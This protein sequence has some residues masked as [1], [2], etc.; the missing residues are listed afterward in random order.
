MS[1]RINSLW[2]KCDGAT[3]I[4]YAFIASLIAVAIAASVAS[5]APPL[6]HI[7]NSVSS[8]F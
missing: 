1:G 7:F 8:G 2:R 3:A 5:V 6:I 4:E